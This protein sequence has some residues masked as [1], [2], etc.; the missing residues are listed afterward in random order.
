MLFLTRR[1]GKYSDLMS[2][3]LVFGT[4]RWFSN[5]IALSTLYG[6]KQEE[7]YSVQDAPWTCQINIVSLGRFSAL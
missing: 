3:S 5:R 2:V 4:D 6:G 1:L 7:L